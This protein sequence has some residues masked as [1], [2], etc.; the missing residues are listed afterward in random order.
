MKYLLLICTDEPFEAPSGELDATAWVEEM[1][2]R[3]VRL[4]GQRLEG[5]EAATTVRVRDGSVLLTDGP[6]A[7]TKEQMGGFDIIDCAD[8]DE[9]VEIASK[10]PMARF[11]MIEVRPFWTE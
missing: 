8:L 7:D 2:G 10:H 1:D 3:G 4:D 11:G 5:P 9:A 6:F